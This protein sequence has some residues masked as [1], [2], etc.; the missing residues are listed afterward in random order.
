[1]ALSKTKL[2]IDSEFTSWLIKDM[3]IL[4]Y[5]MFIKETVLILFYKRY[6]LFLA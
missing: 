2:D 3:Y 4:L 1:M 5:E 6:D